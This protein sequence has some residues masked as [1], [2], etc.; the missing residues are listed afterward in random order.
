MAFNTK[1]HK[2]AI[3]TARLAC[4]LTVLKT[5][6]DIIHGPACAACCGI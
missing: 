4:W 3:E 1:K 5:G 2:F 6:H